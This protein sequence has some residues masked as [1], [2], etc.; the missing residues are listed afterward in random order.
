M[1]NISKFAAFFSKYF[2]TI[3]WAFCGKSAAC[4]AG[5]DPFALLQISCGELRSKTRAQ[6]RR[7]NG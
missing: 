3:L 4:K 6:G 1:P 7:Q 5:K 2:Q